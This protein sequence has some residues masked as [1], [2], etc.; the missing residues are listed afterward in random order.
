[1]DLISLMFIVAGIILL[2]V[3]L[4]GLAIRIL[5]ESKNK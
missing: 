5:K 2:I 4:L 3:A 1:M